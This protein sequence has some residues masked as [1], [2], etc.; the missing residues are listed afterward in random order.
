MKHSDEVIIVKKALDLEKEAQKCNV[1]YQ[2]IKNESAPVISPAPVKRSVEKPDYPTVKS[3]LKFNW[4]KV[5]VPMFVLF[6]LEALCVSLSIF[7]LFVFPIG[8]LSW[9]AWIVF[10]I[11]DH[12][13]EKKANV[14][15][16]SNSPEYQAAC[17]EIDKR[18]HDELNEAENEYNAKMDEYNKTVVVEFNKNL[19]I[20]KSEHEASLGQAKIAKDN[21]D[22]ELENH[23][24]ST[25]VIPAKYHDIDVLDYIYSLISS[26]QYSLKECYNDYE[27]NE[28]RK[29]EEAKIREQQLANELAEAQANL[30]AEQNYLIDEQNSIAKKTRRDQNL[31][32]I[33][34]IMQRHNTNKIL[35][36]K[37]K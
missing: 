34:G 17:A 21:A 19:A 20:W 35:N 24:N 37:D 18:Y 22:K 9:I 28:S 4:R 36:R 14:V 7:E 25:Q 27:R 15:E 29:L 6:L 8:T 23:Y 10:C 12:F 5:L 13:K 26:S 31:S 1:A 2:R 32:N 30:T 11:K 33:V 3:D 16:I